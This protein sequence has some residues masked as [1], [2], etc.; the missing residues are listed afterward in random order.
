MT[1]NFSHPLSTAR[2]VEIPLERDGTAHPDAAAEATANSDSRGAKITIKTM[3]VV[4]E[5]QNQMNIVIRVTPLQSQN[6]FGSSWSRT[7]HDHL[8]I[9]HPQKTCSP[10]AVSPFWLKANC[11][12]LRSTSINLKHTRFSHVNVL[13]VTGAGRGT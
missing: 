7:V 3:R 12:A 6:K 11:S 13:T 9:H 2:I 8:V 5:S 10:G 1:A 4:S